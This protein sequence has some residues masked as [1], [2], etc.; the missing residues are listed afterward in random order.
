M[1]IGSDSETVRSARA[2]MKNQVVATVRVIRK[3]V[4]HPKHQHAATDANDTGHTQDSDGQL[5]EEPHLLRLAF[6]R[7]HLSGTQV[8]HVTAMGCFWVAELGF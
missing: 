6:H 3:K 8:F 7:S 4:I 2:R 5:A 1:A